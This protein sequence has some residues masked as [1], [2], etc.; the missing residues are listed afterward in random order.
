[1]V[2]AYLPLKMISFINYFYSFSKCWRPHI[3]MDIEIRDDIYN[4]IY[5]QLRIIL[6]NGEKHVAKFYS[7]KDI[8]TNYRNIDAIEDEVRNFIK[9]LEDVN[10]GKVE[11]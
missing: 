9:K 4:T 2:E 3:E 10:N 5:K 6:R 8:D 1:M 7:V 11:T